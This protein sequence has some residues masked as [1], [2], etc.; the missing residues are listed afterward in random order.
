MH[1]ADRSTREL[2]SFLFSR[3]FDSP[4]AVVAS[5]RSDDLHRRHPLRTAAAEWAR[6]PGVTRVDLGRL[7]DADVRALVGTPA[8]GGR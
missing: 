7:P 8:P 1:W 3:R 5:Y 4:V 2:L 6:L